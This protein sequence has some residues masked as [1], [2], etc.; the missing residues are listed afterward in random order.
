MSEKHK[1][2]EKIFHCGETYFQSLLEDINKAKKS[3]DIEVYIFSKDNLGKKILKELIAATK[4][5]KI[6]WKNTK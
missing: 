3:I 1:L 6:K 2:Q 4:R 5:K